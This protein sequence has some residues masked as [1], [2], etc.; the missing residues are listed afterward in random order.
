M[1]ELISLRRGLATLAVLGV[2]VAAAFVV[3]PLAGGGGGAAAAPTAKAVRGDVVITVGG[4]GRIVSARSTNTTAATATAAPGA[5]GSTTASTPAAAPADAVFAAASG[6]IARYLVA[7]GERVS[8]GRPIAVLDDAGAAAVALDQARSDLETA[9]LELRQKETADPAR[10]L[11]PSPAELTAARV[12]AAAAE[13]KLTSLVHPPQTDVTAAQ[14]EVRKAE[15][16]LAALRR[17]STPVALAAAERA[18]GVAYQKLA[19]ASGSASSAEVLAAQQE[20]TRAQADVEVLQTGPSATALEAAKLAVTLAQQKLAELPGGALPSEVTQAKLELAKAQA[21]LEALQRTPTATAVAAARTAVDLAAAKLAN[22]A[23]PLA[24]TSARAELDKARSELQTARLRA[25]AAAMK[26]ARLAVMLA[27]QKL[28]QVRRPAPGARDTARVELTK[29]LADLDALRRRGGSAGAI[30][31]ALARVKIGSAEARV[32]AGEVQAGRLTVTAPLAGTVTALLSVAGSPVD[33]TTPIAIV[34]DLDHFAVDVD[35]SEFD[36]AQVRRG[37]V[38]VVSVDALGG[39]RYP[40]TVVFEALAGVENGGVVTFPVRIGL[41]R[42]PGIKPGM[43]VSV[44]IVVARRRRVVHVPLEA[45]A[46]DGDEATV[47]VVDAAGA[48]AVRIVELGLADNKIVEIRSGLK[49][50]E[51]VLLEAGGGA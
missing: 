48:Q 27:Q 15:A 13:R 49:V 32:A 46:Q 26:A 44:R 37:Q 41:T 7:P 17:H 1:N 9:R 47:T 38:A 3:W 6:R 34:A 28:A 45:V 22:A 21:D 24:V 25:G 40:G 33:A 51:R 39:K 23:S 50:G 11:P 30:D 43:N 10:G 2:G 31:L 14:L 5:Q 4:V 42:V 12:A 18:V 35:L 8:A 20:L 16:D 36:V 19:Q 29:A